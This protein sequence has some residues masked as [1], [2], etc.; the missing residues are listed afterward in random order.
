MRPTELKL[1]IGQVY[2]RLYDKHSRFR[3]VL[4]EGPPGVGKTDIVGQVAKELG[5]NYLEVNLTC[6]D[7]GDIKFPIV[8]GDDVK[9][10]NSIFPEGDWEGICLID[11]LGQAEMPVMKAVCQVIHARMIGQ[12]P[13]AKR[14]M[15]VLCT[16]GQRDRAGSSRIITPVLSRCVRYQ[17]ECN[18]NDWTEWANANEVDHRIISFLQWKPSLLHQFDPERAELPFP[19]PRTWHLA[20]D[21]SQAVQETLLLDSIKGC[22]GESAGN[23]CYGFLEICDACEVKY[24]IRRILSNPDD[25]P[26]PRLSEGAIL[27]AMG[28]ALAEQCKQKKKSITHNCMRYAMRMPLEFASYAVRSIIQSGGSMDAMTA[29]GAS[30]FIDTN[31]NIIL[32]V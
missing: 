15:F 3:P 11:E 21:M 20:S 26:V 8:K 19:C 25:V 31:K 10:R 5:V 16:N 23:E 32:A 9:W 4:I 24:P 22:V 30:K 28:G 13:I 18:L 1:A 27:W 17:F 2:K 7:A 6:H 29:P 14:C 12:T